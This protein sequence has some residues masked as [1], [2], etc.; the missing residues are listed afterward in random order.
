MV[1]VARWSLPKPEFNSSTSILQLL[2]S[3]IFFSQAAK[4][5]HI[6][7]GAYLLAILPFDSRQ[8]PGTRKPF[9][10]RNWAII[11]CHIPKDNL[12]I[13][14]KHCQ[15]RPLFNLF[16]SFQKHYK[17]YNKY[18]CM[19]KCPSSIRVPGLEHEPP[20]IITWP[21]LLPQISRS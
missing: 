13:F 18:V 11:N 6:A 7:Y 12:K 17:F 19:W 2:L 16:S 10:A 15:P 4:R 21:G 8:G 1:Q 5:L 14:F 9:L 3:I 20:P